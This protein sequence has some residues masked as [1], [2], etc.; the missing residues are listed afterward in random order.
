[1][2]VARGLVTER[3]IEQALRRQERTGERLGVILI[4]R[5]H[6][7][8]EQLVELL[9]AQQPRMRIGEMLIARGLVTEQIVQEA[10]ARQERTGERLGAIL[11]SDQRLSEQAFVDAL[12]EQLH[13]PAVS[14]TERVPVEWA[15]TQA[16][17]EALAR[18]YGCVPFSIEGAA[19]RVAF[20]AAPTAEQLR[21]LSSDCG[22]QVK[23]TL[24]PRRQIERFSHRLYD[25]F[26]DRESRDGLRRRRP[27]N[28]AAT[29]I[30]RR[31][32]AAGAA[33]LIALGAGVALASADTLTVV[34][35]AVC[36]WY[37]LCTTY[38]LVVIAL[39][40]N[41]HTTGELKFTAAQL[42]GLDERT[43]PTYTILVPLY[44]EAAVVGRLAAGI[45]SLDYPKSKLDVRLL[46]E[47][48]DPETIAAVDALDLPPHFKLVVCPDTQP[49][50]KPKACN[51]GLWQAQGEY[52]V[53]Y[54][55]E[56]QPD[57]QQLKKALLAFRASGPEVV[58]VQAKLN[59][60]NSRQ[61]ALTR[62][63]AAEYAMLF[64]LTLPGLAR[65]KAPI[66]LGGT[67]N[68]FRRQVLMD[69]GAW[70]P[71]NVTEDADL[72]IRLHKDGYRTTM[73]DSTTLEEA[74]SRVG[75]WI[76]QRSRWN[77]GYFIT[78]LVHMRAPLQLARELGPA[79]FLSFQMMLGAPF[80]LLLNPL[81]WAL[82]AFTW[83]HHVDAFDGLALH[84]MSL[85]LLVIGN[86]S[87]VAI[88]VWGVCKR[89]AFSS[90]PI[91]LLTF[92]YWALMSIAA[93]KALWQLIT[94]PF[95]W[96]KTVHGLDAG[97]ADHLTLAP[98]KLAD[99][100]AA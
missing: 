71:H 47:Q 79:G 62:W 26:Y 98:Q 19:L 38:K 54:D 46:C 31:Q 5:G 53:I 13:V 3:V 55:A 28:S 77:K 22:W 36:V 48:D 30:T 67:S 95:Y 78:W 80:A 17:P 100:V 69:V 23:P 56:D 89:R 34:L 44:R 66:P 90:V 45:A 91:T 51:Y 41:R 40:S 14:L 1:M 32:V 27:R 83:T 8:E 16:L 2:L 6:I 96:E 21:N 92:A 52:V 64:D 63:F 61:N 39:S 20:E 75:N 68:H 74:N 70:D 43:L 84:D 97:H 76:R 82:T 9:A 37:L 72:G 94:K 24:A 58:C 86:L 15:L 29:V 33:G 99:P 42:A 87:W 12:S 88:S 50:T 18:T 49:K 11:L 81:L 60:F 35:L 65:M 93:Y 25:E 85:F 59:Y 7:T 57:P 10:L 73:I 4:A